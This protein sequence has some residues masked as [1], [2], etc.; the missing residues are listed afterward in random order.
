MLG[1]KKYLVEEEERLKR[2]KQ[3]VEKRLVD[4]PEGNLRITSSGKHIQYMHCKEKEGIYH[5]QGEYL[6]KEDMPLVRRLAQKAY[7]QKIKRLVDK[8]LKQIQN[9]NKDYAD[10]E[11]ENVF[12]LMN[13]K[14]Q[15][16]VNPV[17]MTWQQTVSAW[18][19]I[20]YVGKEFKDGTLEIYTKKGERVRSKSEKLIADTLFEMGIEYKYECPLNLKGYGIVYPD[21]TIL[22]AKIQKEMYWEHDGRM[23]DPQYSEK[24]VR[25]IAS[26]I[27][28][29]IIN[30]DRL[31]LTFETS[32][33]VLSDKIIR[34]M[35]NNYLL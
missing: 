35:I 25:K 3:V 17:E 31:I 9:M 4:I 12:T 1:L 22:S 28:N 26:Y 32:N 5:K 16:L 27:A 18:K 10:N 30:G 6:K 14:R 24:A 7:D 29:G 21:F 15:E 11:I 8:R 2:I 19:T 23:D 20:P 33:V 34:K 13:V